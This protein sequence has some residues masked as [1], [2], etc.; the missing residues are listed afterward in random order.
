MVKVQNFDANVSVEELLEDVIKCMWELTLKENEV[1]WHLNELTRPKRVR[2]EKS[3]AAEEKLK[4][5]LSNISCFQNELRIITK[6][7]QDVL[8]MSMSK[9]IHWKDM[10]D[11]TKIVKIQI[12]LAIVRNADCFR[13]KSPYLKIPSTD[14]PLKLTTLV[15]QQPIFNNS[16]LNHYTLREII[17]PL[18]KS[19]SVGPG[20]SS[21]IQVRTGG[22]TMVTGTKKDDTATESGNVAKLIIKHALDLEQKMRGGYDLVN[23]ERIYATQFLTSF[24]NVHSSTENLNLQD[25]CT[26]LD[27]VENLESSC[28]ELSENL[29]KYP[30]TSKIIE[31][32]KQSSEHVKNINKPQ[33]ITKDGYDSSEIKKISDSTENLLAKTIGGTKTKRALEETLANLNTIFKKLENMEEYFSEQNITVVQET[34][35]KKYVNSI[36]DEE[37]YVD[38]ENNQ[39][40]LSDEDEESS[41]EIYYNANDYFAKTEK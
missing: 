22:T 23:A 33:K 35:S 31:N 5:F 38:T 37:K 17:E 41:D 9:K 8:H 12:C 25:I 7:L 14:S 29:A 18:T 21:I 15:L 30:D 32:T 28:K 3:K 27:N 34:D 11:E 20:L 19:T 4:L 2:K 36:S 10:L 16:I 40:H 13:F 6:G 26:A 24:Q 1:S 39:T